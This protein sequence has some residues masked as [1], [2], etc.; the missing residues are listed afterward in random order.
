MPQKVATKRI[1]YCV[2]CIVIFLFLLVF[3]SVIH[4]VQVFDGDDWTYIGYARDAL[5]DANAWN[6]TRVLPE[7]LMPAVGSLA[8]FVVT[9]ILGD[10]LT[11]MTLTYAVV[12][13]AVI[14]CYLHLFTRMISERFSLEDNTAIIVSFLFFLAHF[15]LFRIQDSGNKHLFLSRNLTC[16]FYYTIPTL[17]NGS[18]VLVFERKPD[19]WKEI[20]PI[21][22]GGLI[23]LLYLG[24]YSNLFSSIV[25][26]AYS[27]TV[28][29]QRMITDWLATKKWNTL[30]KTLR[31]SSIFVGIIVIWVVSLFFELKG[32]RAAQVGTM[33]TAESIHLALDNLLNSFKGINQYFALFVLVFVLLAAI[34]GFS[35]LK[36]KT[37]EVWAYWRTAFHFLFA[38][39]VV[40]VYQVLLCGVTSLSGYLKCSDVLVSIYLYLLIGLLCIVCYVIKKLPGVRVLLPVIACIAV[41]NCNTYSTTYAE[42]YQTQIH[43]E[44][45]K[46]ITET[47][48]TQIC[49]ASENNQTSV[50][51]E[52][53]FF[54]SNDNWPLS[55]WLGERMSRTLYKHGQINKPI[56]I[57]ITPSLEMNEKFSIE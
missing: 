50:E 20:S 32:G 40:A 11:A 13:S 39:I 16:Y 41:F 7:I 57:V 14:L 38:G 37:S 25:L 8:A 55:T 35:D 46:E 30:W 28:I 2:F 49:D 48:Y 12:I 42:P 31:S 33:G 18:L 54:D 1:S 3:F 47:V 24:I 27:G 56:E 52:V 21:Q 36:K 53:P 9:P 51:I 43:H 19:I 17:L 5:P 29:L 10:Y 6:P 23:L 45:V 26:V 34:L 4:P 15:W 22:K 44:V